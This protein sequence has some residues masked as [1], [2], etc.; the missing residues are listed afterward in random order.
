MPAISALELEEKARTLPVQP[1]Y[2]LVGKNDTLRALSLRLIESVAAPPDHPGGV[3]T[4]LEEVPEPSAVFDELRTAPFMGLEG[5]RVVV[6]ENGD[7]FLKDNADRLVRYLERP[8]PT[9][10][11]VLLLGALD[12]R[13]RAAKALEEHGLVVEC[14]R[15]TWRQAESWLRE[16]ARQMG[17]RITPQAASDLV[18]SVGADLMTLRSE[19]DKLVTYCQ[20]EDTITRQAVDA[21]GAGSRSR[22]IFDL[23]DA[24]SRG[25]RAEAMRLCNQLLLRGEA[26][27]AIIAVLARQ[28]RQLWQIKRLRADGASQNQMAGRIGIPPFAVRRGAQ[29]VD[30]LSEDWFAEQ[31]T[32]L[33]EADYELKTASLRA[34]D[35]E[36]WVGN[37]VARLCQVAERAGQERG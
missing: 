11:L 9:G 8:S 37:L 16:Q 20:P 31:L 12:G 7:E 24:I 6:V 30:R 2:A 1:A 23:G 35:E 29:V 5:R 32:V 10:C 25:K 33:S 3:L 4:R 13:T 27:E 21:V 14:G 17:A 15:V 36:A 22:S 26:P 34:G 28:V 18:R 19:L